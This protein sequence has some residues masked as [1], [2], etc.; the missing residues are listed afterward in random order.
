M[1]PHG[2]SA[3]LQRFDYVSIVT[4]VGRFSVAMPQGAFCRLASRY[5][6]G[7]NRLHNGYVAAMRPQVTAMYRCIRYVT[8]V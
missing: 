8:A 6:A 4:T 2:F 5:V 7:G 3:Q 1:R